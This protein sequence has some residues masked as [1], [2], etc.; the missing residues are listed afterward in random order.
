MTWDEF[1]MGMAFYVAMKSK[2]E[3]T[4]VGSVIA[5]PDNEFISMGFNGIPRGVKDKKERLISPEKYIW[6]EHAER[7]AIDNAARVGQRLKGCHM[8]CT[9]LTCSDCAKG[10]IQSGISKLTVESPLC[11]A[12]KPAWNKSWRLA[13]MMLREAGVDVRMV[14]TNIPNVIT[15][16]ISG[17]T[18]DLTRSKGK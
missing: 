17:E 14:S 8:Y 12:T 6:V 1:F 10:I 2:D 18:F 13:D 4:K 9:F 11:I 7:N 16:R 15:G 5:G 3:S